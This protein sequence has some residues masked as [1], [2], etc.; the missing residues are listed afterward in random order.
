M[1]PSFGRPEGIVST[2][3]MFH[4]SQGENEQQEGMKG[5]TAMIASEAE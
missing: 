1:M 2:G 5:F 4:A 3:G